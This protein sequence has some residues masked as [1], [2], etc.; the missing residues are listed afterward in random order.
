MVSWNRPWLLNPLRSSWSPSH[1][2]WRYVMLRPAVRP[3]HF[4]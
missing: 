1:H 3:F 4:N 2:I